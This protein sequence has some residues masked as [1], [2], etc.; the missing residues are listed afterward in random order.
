MRYEI[1]LIKNAELTLL[2][3]LLGATDDAAEAKQIADDNSTFQW[4]SAIVDRQNETV[5][6]GGGIESLDGIEI[7]A[8]L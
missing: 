7:E 6:W 3:T 4:G 5:D 2:G 1:R 8:S